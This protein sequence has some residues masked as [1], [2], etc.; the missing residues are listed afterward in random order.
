VLISLLAGVGSWFGVTQL[1]HRQPDPVASTP[2]KQIEFN[3]PTI[4]TDT[5][6]TLPTTGD[7]IRPEMDRAIEKEGKVDAKTPVRY[8][9]AAIAGDNLD[10]QLVPLNTPSPDPSKSLLPIDP[11]TSTTSPNVTQPKT[12]TTIPIAVATPVPTQVLMTIISPTGGPIDD[13]ADRVLSW[14]GQLS[15]SGDYT[16]ELRPITGLVGGTFPYKL[17]VTQLSVAPATAPVNISPNPAGSNP[18]LGAPIPINGNTGL[19]AIP[20][21]PTTTIP[22]NN[23]PTFTPVPVPIEVPKATPNVTPTEPERPRRKR[24]R[25]QTSAEPTPQTKRE[26]VESSDPETPTPRRNRKRQTKVEVQPQ[27]SSTPKPDLSENT[28]ITPPKQEEQIP[29]VVPDAKTTIPVPTKTPAPTKTEIDRKDPPVN[30]S[31]NDPD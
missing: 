14:R 26:R 10:I 20:T 23:L 4:A 28:T 5:S 2:P 6:T 29:I 25:N 18:Q 3:N 24:K 17:S 7:T 21:D 31:N 9:I 13:K 12:K 15:T 11:K 22:S 8:K 30:G 1:L 27:P 16:I 19:K